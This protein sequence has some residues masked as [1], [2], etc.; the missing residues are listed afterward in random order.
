C[1]KACKL[2]QPLW[3]TVW[4]F[5]KK[6]KIELSYDL[7]IAVLGIY[8][9]DTKML[10]HGAPGGTCTQMLI[11]A[12]AIIAKLLLESKCPLTDEWIKKMWYIYI[13]KSCLAIKK[14]EILPFATMWMKLECIMLSEISQ[15]EKEKSHVTLLMWNL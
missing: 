15:S 3:K 12:L 7:A 1:F 5:L 11:A 10:I 2:V 4:R 14:N 6:L 13:M 9:K 8:P